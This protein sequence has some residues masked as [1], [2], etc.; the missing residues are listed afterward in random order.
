LVELEIR[1]TLCE[2]MDGDECT[3]IETG[4]KST[5]KVA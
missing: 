5:Q 3:D 1:K 2:W 4:L